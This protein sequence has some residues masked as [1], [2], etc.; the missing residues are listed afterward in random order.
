MS[1][2]FASAPSESSLELEDAS[3]PSWVSRPHKCQHASRPAQY[4]VQTLSALEL[5]AGA[6]Y[7]LHYPLEIGADLKPKEKE[8]AKEQALLLFLSSLLVSSKLA[9]GL[10]YKK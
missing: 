8:L 4:L 6:S 7:H 3:R 10:V 5:P 9:T 2:T 1:S